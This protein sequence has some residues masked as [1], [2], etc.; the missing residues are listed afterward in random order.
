MKNFDIRKE[1]NGVTSQSVRKEFKAHVSENYL[2]IHLFWAGKGTTS[3]PTQGTYG[4]TVAAISAT[5][6]NSGRLGIS[7]FLHMCYIIDY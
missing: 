3:I 7:F 1:A 6:G 4:P 5:P 2:D